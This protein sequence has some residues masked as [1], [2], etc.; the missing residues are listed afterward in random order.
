[1]RT[2]GIWRLALASLAAL[3][4]GLGAIACGDSKSSSANTTASTGPARAT[5]TV[6]LDWVPNTNHTGIFVAKAKGYFDA[7]NIDLKILPY[8]GASTDV[9]VSQGKADLAISFVPSVLVSRSAGID[10]KAVGA[11]MSRN[12]EALVVLADSKFKQPKDF[13]VGTT[14]GGFGLPYEE[15]TWTALI[16]ADGATDV[17]F[18]P[19]TLNTAAYEALYQKKIDWSALFLGW[20]AIEAKQRGINLRLFPLPKYLGVAGDFPSTILVSSDA[21]IAAKPDVL[22]RGLAAISQGYTFAAQNPAEAAQILIDQNPEL[23]KNTKL[24]KASADYLAP[25]YVGDS[26]QWGLFKP[27]PW[28]ELGTILSDAGALAD[29]SGTPVKAPDF[30][31]YWTN[32]LL[33]AK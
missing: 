8:S 9:L 33:P 20:E 29:K 22:K 27:E 28:T 31:T 16:K 17:N 3:A 6:A 10:V 24:V 1:M 26:A 19:V 15:P 32:D 4:V 18:K 14:Y 11:V 5:L 13:A 12:T 23:Q 7:Q 21:T 25:V 30:A 2:T